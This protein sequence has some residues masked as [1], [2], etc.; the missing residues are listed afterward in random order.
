MNKIITKHSHV[1]GRVPRDLALGE[2]AVNTEDGV[3]FFRSPSHQMHQISA[4]KPSALDTLN[5]WLAFFL[6]AVWLIATVV[7]FEKIFV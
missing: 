2:I 5:R 3:L 6:L 1:C 4:T 7:L